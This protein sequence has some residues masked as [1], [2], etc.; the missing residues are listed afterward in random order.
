MDS[1]QD[2]TV[3]STIPTKTVNQIAAIAIM[4]ETRS[5][6]QGDSVAVGGASERLRHVIGGDDQGRC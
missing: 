3:R 2:R 6:E 5:L 4:K 1:L